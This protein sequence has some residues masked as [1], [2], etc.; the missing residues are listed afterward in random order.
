MMKVRAGDSIA[1]FIIHP[2]IT[3]VIG[4]LIGGKI[5][6]RWSAYAHMALVIPILMMQLIKSALVRAS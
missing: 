1:A 4:L 3:C 5:R 6:I 2:I